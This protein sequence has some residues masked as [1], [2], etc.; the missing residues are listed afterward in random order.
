MSIRDRVAD[1][2]V[3]RIAKSAL[4]RRAQIKR[5]YGEFFG[6]VSA[7]LFEADPIGLNF[8]DNT[9]EY[10]PEAVTII[11]R[12]RACNGPDDVA[13]VVFEEFVRWFTVEDA[14]PRESYLEVSGRIW[15]SW[16]RFSSQNAV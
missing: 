12:L 8:S 2:R 5:E 15:V 16:Q 9:D 1:Y 14:G 3:R 13:A 4:A 7:L 10:E 6:E 11:P